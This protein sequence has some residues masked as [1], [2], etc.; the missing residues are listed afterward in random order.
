MVDF[1][2]TEGR[3][4]ASWREQGVT[5]I[6]GLDGPYV[7]LDRLLIPKSDFRVMNLAK[8]ID[9]DRQFDFCR[10]EIKDEPGVQPW[11]RFNLFSFC[12][13]NLLHRLP[14]QLTETLLDPEMPI[15]DVSP[16]WYRLRKQMVRRLPF[17]MRQWLAKCAV[18]IR[19]HWPYRLVD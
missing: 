7:D 4:L 2:C 11:Y 3:W 5:E 18:Y 12:N 6:L 10:I 16:R 1:G 15:P 19:V 17:F 14:T 9:F 8:F 13:K